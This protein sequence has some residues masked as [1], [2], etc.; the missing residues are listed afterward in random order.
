MKSEKILLR[1]PKTETGKPIVY[2]LIK[3]YNLVVNI[4]VAKVTQDKEGYLVVNL[5]GEEA[6][7]AR[8]KAFL[9]GMQVQ[10][11]SVENGIL[12]DNNLCT[13]CG[14]CVSHCPTNAL[15]IAD[16]RTMQVDLDQS[17]CISCSLCTTNCPFG[18]CTSV[19]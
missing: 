17:L 3:D 9:C 6:D 14:N 12:R 19:L 10:V 8:G 16:R 2:Q 7:L 5:T 13:H 4:Y 1:F 11:E 18:A 15:H